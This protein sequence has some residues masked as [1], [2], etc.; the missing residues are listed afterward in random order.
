MQFYQCKGTIFFLYVQVFLHFYAKY[1]QFL[2]VLCF[3]VQFICFF[4]QEKFCLSLLC[5]LKTFCIFVRFLSWFIMLWR[6]FLS[7]MKIG[8]FTIGGGYAM[9]PVIEAEVVTKHKWVT[10]EDFLDMVVLAQTAPGILAMNISILVGE[11]IAGKRGAFVSA[12]GAGLPSF[13]VI[14]IFAMFLNQFQDNE[15]VSKVFRAVRPA[16]IALIAVPVFKLAKTAKITMR[17]VWI[18]IL[19]ALLIWLLGISPI[20]IILV[21][22]VVGIALKFKVWHKKQ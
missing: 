11:K 15:Y 14:L 13:I 21:A 18:P 4:L 1:M 22:I 19:V 10:A 17:T 7:F 2:F 9:L 5:R 16:V 20:W 8:A 12:L 3:Y 6:L